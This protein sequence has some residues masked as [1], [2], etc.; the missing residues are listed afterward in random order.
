MKLK[1]IYRISDAGN[2]KPKL[3]GGSKQK[4]LENALQVFGKESIVVQAD[5]CTEA[6]LRIL[7]QLGLDFQTSSLGNAESWRLVA[8]RALKESEAGT[9]LYFLE[10]DYLHIK[11]AA[12]VILDGLTRADYVSVYDHPDKYIDGPNPF[13]SKGGEESRVLLGKLCHWK[14]SNSTTMTF[15]VRKETLAADWH[16]WEEFT[17]AGFPDDFHAFLRLC[18]LGSWENRIFGSGRKLFTSLPAFATHTELEWI[19][20]LRNWTSISENEPG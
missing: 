2:P 12:E 18:S 5:H 15:A 19:A 8:S 7:E 1:V 16:V 20:P 10:D 11:G 17:S 9:A 6:T 13:V 4:C 3:Q 14:I